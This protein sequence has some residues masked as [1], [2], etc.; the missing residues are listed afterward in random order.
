MRDLLKSVNRWCLDLMFPKHCLGCGQEGSYLCPD[1]FNSL[2]VSLCANCFICGQRSPSGRACDSCRRR[3]K[4]AL[5]GILVAANWKNLLLRQIIYEYKYRFVKELADP[6]SRLMA[7]FLETSLPESWQARQADHS[8]D[9][10]ILIPVPLHGRRFA[11]RG[12]NQA[13][14][15]AQ[16][17]SPYLNVSPTRNILF[18]S[19]HTLPQRA[20]KTQTERTANIKNAFALMPNFNTAKNNFLKNKVVILVDDICTTGATFEDCARALKPLNPKEIWGLVV[21]RG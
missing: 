1:C 13:E 11:W 8:T 6:L 19:R 17:I 2:P 21:A 9:S 10:P 4:T 16:K 7:N 18:R 15:L 20:T 5:T 12:F 3:T 14:L